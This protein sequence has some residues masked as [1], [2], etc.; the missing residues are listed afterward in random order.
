[1]SALYYQLTVT[2]QYGNVLDE[3]VHTSISLLVQELPEVRKKAEEK[4]KEREE[5]Y[6][7]VRR[8]EL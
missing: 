6:R 1:M 3:R 5:R 4:V 2:D 8:I 7:Q